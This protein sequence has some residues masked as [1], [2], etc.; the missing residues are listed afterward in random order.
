LIRTLLVAAA[1]TLPAAAWAQGS[2]ARSE[3]NAIAFEPAS[4]EEGRRVL[5][6]GP[7]R[8]L[9]TP[10]AAAR[11]ARDGDAILIDAA[12]YPESRSVW[13]QNRL[14]LRGIGGR[15]HLR[16]GA[17]LAQG[18][19]IWVFNGDEVVVENIEFSGARLASGNGAASPCAAR[20]STTTTPGSSRTTIGD[21]RS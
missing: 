13:Q 16:A 1:L 19:A 10:A 8:E 14:L 11:V 9:A 17:K 20:T 12:D 18:K 15:P 4:L 3:D 6:V 2:C 7:G 21:R 5:R